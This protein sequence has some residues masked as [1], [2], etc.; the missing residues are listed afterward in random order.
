GVRDLLGPGADY[1]PI[2]TLNAGTIHGGAKVNVIAYDCTFEFEA[3]IPIGTDIDAMVALT[4]EIVG[5][6]PEA[7]ITALH[8]SAPDYCDP[9]DTLAVVLQDT[10]ESLGR[11]RPSM[12]VSSA[13]SDCKYWR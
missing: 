7:E 11:P 8:I 4:R 5:R 12:F 6:H 10:V 9:T 3:R 13:L 1:I 2:I